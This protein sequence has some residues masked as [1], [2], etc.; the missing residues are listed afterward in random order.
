MLENKSR[1]F[2]QLALVASKQSKCLKRQIGAVIVDDQFHVL[3]LGYNGVPKGFSHCERCLRDIK[4]IDVVEDKLPDCPAIHAE[5]N[6][7]LQCSNI[8]NAIA[9]YVTTF[10]CIHCTKMICNTNIKNIFYL[11]E[12]ET[13]PQNKKIIDDMLCTAEIICSKIDIGD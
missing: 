10:P 6:S 2:M 7:V 9:I 11:T 8:H 4:N 13:D 12:Y 1:Y 5:L 3:S